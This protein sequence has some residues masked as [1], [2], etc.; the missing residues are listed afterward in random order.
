MTTHNFFPF[1]PATFEFPGMFENFKE[2]VEMNPEIKFVE[3]AESNRGVIIVSIN[4]INFETPA[5]KI[6]QEFIDNPLL[7]DGHAFDLGVYVLITSIDPLRI[8][9]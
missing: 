4:E 6:Y 3:K 8:Y 9:R 2:F 5:K 1:I 7:I